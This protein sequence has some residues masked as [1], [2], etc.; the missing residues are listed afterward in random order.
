M[1]RPLL[2]STSTLTTRRLPRAPRH[3]RFA[4]NRTPDAS[5]KNPNSR[6]PSTGRSSATSASP[7]PSEA[8]SNKSSPAASPVSSPDPSTDWEENPNFN[9]SDFDELPHTNFGVNQHMLINAEF[10]EALRQVLWQFR[11]PIRYAFA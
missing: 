8:T 9:I 7:S 10:K 5:E 3:S 6:D 11:A 4:S 2:R 1:A